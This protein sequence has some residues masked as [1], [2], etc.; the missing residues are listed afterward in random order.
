MIGIQALKS[1]GPNDSTPCSQQRATLTLPKERLTRTRCGVRKAE[2]KS[3]GELD[4]HH[5]LSKFYHDQIAF[6]DFDHVD[7]STLERSQVLSL[8]LSPKGKALRELLLGEMKEVSD[9]MFRSSLRRLFSQVSQIQCPWS[10]K[11]RAS[12]PR[13]TTSTIVDVVVELR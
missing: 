1:C 8:L 13:K 12:G 9:L 2:K 11:S 3:A 4:S 10:R 6:I 5:F 7:T